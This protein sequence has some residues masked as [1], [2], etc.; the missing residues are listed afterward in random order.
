M[1]EKGKISSMQMAIMF[2]PT[3][4][5]TAILSVPGGTAQFAGNDMWISPIWSSLIGFLVVYL[6]FRLHKLY[7]KQTIIQYSEKIL[8]K[9]LGKALGVILVMNLLFANGNATKQYME[10]VVGAFLPYTPTVLVGASL[11]LVCGFA[12]RGGLEV[13]GRAAE[14][15][16][17]LY[18]FSLV[19]IIVF[20]IPE[21]KPQNMFPIMENGLKPSI[22]GAA[23]PGS[24]L[25]LFFLIS[26]ILW[27]V[28]SQYG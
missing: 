3:I 25:T 2:Y 28:F 17:P 26:Y 18:I 15:F 9:Y 8:G 5:A 21:F 1:I 24:M 13:V 10:L 6:A 12:V 20:L 27:F 19:M 7:P 4:I 23:I 11:I 14:L 16:I 22:K